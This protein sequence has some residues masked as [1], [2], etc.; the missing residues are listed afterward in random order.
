MESTSKIEQ[1]PLGEVNLDNVLPKCILCK[2]VPER[3]ITDGFLMIGQF[4][5]S[6]CEQRLLTLDYNDPTYSVM[7]KTLKDVIYCSKR[8]NPIKEAMKD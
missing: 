1:Q 8:K 6:R 7:I 3:G 4:I 5:C 2:K